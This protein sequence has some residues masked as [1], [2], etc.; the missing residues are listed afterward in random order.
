MLREIVKLNLFIKAYGESEDKDDAISILNTY[1]HDYDISS[2]SIKMY[3]IDFIGMYPVFKQEIELRVLKTLFDNYKNYRKA[4]EKDDSILLTL[5][6]AEGSILIDYRKYIGGTTNIT[7][8]LLRLIQDFE[9]ERKV[10]EIF[11][12]KNLGQDLKPKLEISRD[13]IYNNVCNHRSPSFEHLRP[14]KQ[15][16]EDMQIEIL[17]FALPKIITGYENTIFKEIEPIDLKLYFETID[18]TDRAIYETLS[19]MK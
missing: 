11:S 1:L 2:N 14:R 16:I 9:N 18:K 3:K 5:A 10:Q 15:S 12:F 17:K 19:A 4:E 7:K 6:E 13:L 8:N